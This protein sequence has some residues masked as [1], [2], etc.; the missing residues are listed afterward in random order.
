MVWIDTTKA[1]DPSQWVI[2]DEMRKGDYVEGV[3]QEI[4]E[5]RPRMKV[6]KVWGDPLYYLCSM[7]SINRKAQEMVKGLIG[8]K[9]RLV[10][11]E[12]AKLNLQYEQ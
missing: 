9:I 5:H 3:L 8:K 6:L 1:D 11:T 10:K 2:T 7:W 12:D 4:Y